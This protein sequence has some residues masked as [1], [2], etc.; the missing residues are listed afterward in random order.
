MHLFKWKAKRA[1]G[2]I[3]VYGEDAEGLPHKVVGVD[4]ITPAA[5][6]GHC[7]ATDKNGESHTLAV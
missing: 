2:R 6:H 5:G 1:G 3:T 4:Q 7:V